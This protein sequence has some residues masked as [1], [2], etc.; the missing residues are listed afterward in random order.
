M[1]NIFKKQFLKELLISS[2]V[3]CVLHL[4]ALQYFL[5][6]TID[7]YDILTH[8]LGGVTMGFLATY[9][10]FT[11]KYIKPLYSIRD[12]KWTVFLTISFF[13]LS[14]GLTWELWELF[15]GFSD[16]LEDRVDTIIDLIMDMLGAFSVFIYVKDK[17]K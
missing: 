11:S 2:I 9:I 6:W 7:W 8:Y 14:V 16:V 3:V 12:H 13:T 4:L 10:F 17:I 15:V 1:D 5:Y